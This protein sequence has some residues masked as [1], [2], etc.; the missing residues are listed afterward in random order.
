[1]IKIALSFL[2]R[3]LEQFSSANIV[4]SYL[5][6]KS[7][8]P[9]NEENK[10]YITLLNI[11]EEKSTKAPYTYKKTQ[12]E[13]NPQKYIT[14]NPEMTLN[15][16]VMV[17]STGN[18]EEALKNIS[19]V[20]EIFAEKNAFDK[21][22]FN[23]DEKK[24]LDE[25]WL[26]IQNISLDQSNNLWQALANHILPHIIYKVRTLAFVPDLQIGKEQTEVRGREIISKNI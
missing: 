8:D 4:N 5:P 21:V 13:S 6:S 25:L 10:I 2:K 19:N 24:V 17:S 23:V 3:Y 22:D 18:Y 20:V 12:L 14:T 1:M 7:S 26:D 15:L 9:A 11:E 16:Y